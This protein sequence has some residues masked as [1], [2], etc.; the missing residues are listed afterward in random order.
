MSRYKQL[1]TRLPLF[2]RYVSNIICSTE[3]SCNLWH[4][5]DTFSHCATMQM[6]AIISVSY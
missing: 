6:V 4:H 5:C 2:L 1:L 3:F